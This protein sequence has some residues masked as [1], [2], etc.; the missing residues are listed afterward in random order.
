[1]KRTLAHRLISRVEE[2]EVAQ[3]VRAALFSTVNLGDLFYPKSGDHGQNQGYRNKIAR[4]HL[5]FLLYDRESLKPL[6][7]IELDDS[8]HNRPDRQARDKFVDGVFAAAGL[9]LLHVPVSYSYPTKKLRAYLRRKAGLA[10]EEPILSPAHSRLRWWHRWKRDKWKRPFPSAPNV[11]PPWSAARRKKGLTRVTRFGVVPSLFP[12]PALP[13]DS[14]REDSRIGKTAVP[15][16]KVSAFSSFMVLAYCV[17]KPARMMIGQ[18]FWLIVAAKLTG[19][20][21][22]GNGR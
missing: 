7:A 15:C 18:R 5:G 8:S 6:L 13:G 4:K 2:R 11:T 9:P 10:D 1:L 20:G 14:S 19:S 22:A 12:L 16:G 3:P 17:A 21:N